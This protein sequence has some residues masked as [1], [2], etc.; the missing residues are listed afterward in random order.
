MRMRRVSHP[1]VADSDSAGLRGAA[2]A[3]GCVDLGMVSLVSPISAALSNDSLRQ[4]CLSLSGA[5]SYREPSSSC[6][7]AR[8]R[9]T[10][11][12]F[13]SLDLARQLAARNALVAVYTGYPRFK[14]RDVRIAPERLRSFWLFRSAYMVLSRLRFK[15]SGVMRNL[16][17]ASRP[18][19]MNTWR[20]RCQIVMLSVEW[21]EA[22]SDLRGWQG[23][24]VP[25]LFATSVHRTSG[26]GSNS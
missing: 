18:P 16:D 25:E 4:I 7:D 2:L 14:L 22:R 24:E 3:L 23:S 1:S 13:H 11:G 8:R 17:W 20:E 6:H 5:R 9:S 19:S 10:F 12:V 26:I 15:P 21:R